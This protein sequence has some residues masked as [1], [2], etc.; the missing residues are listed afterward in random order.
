MVWFL[1]EH[2][3]GQNEERFYFH[4]DSAQGKHFDEIASRVGKIDIAFIENGQYDER[5]PNNHLFPE[6]TAQLAANYSQQDLCPFT[7]GLSPCLAYVE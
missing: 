4:G 6:Q 5:W 7:G 2:K 3:R 1:I